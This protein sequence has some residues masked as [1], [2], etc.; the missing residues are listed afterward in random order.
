MTE[1]P[2]AVPLEP[3]ATLGILGGG[4]LGRLLVMAAAKL[5]LRC[6]VFCP[7][8]DSPAFEV[9]A[10]VTSAAYDDEGALQLFAHRVDVVT[11]EFENVPAHVAGLLAAQRPVYPPVAALD[12]TQDRL[13]EKRLA[14]SLGLATAPFAAVDDA[15]GLARQLNEIG[16]PALLKTRRFGYDGKGQAHIGNL[17]E[18]PDAFGAIGWQPAILE[19]VVLFSK[20][21]SVVAARG[22]DGAFAAYDPIENEHEDGILRRSRVPAR[23]L[24]ATT[25]AAVETA[26]TIGEALGF[27]GVFCVEMFVVEDTGGERLL[28]NEIAPRVHNSGHW[29]LDGCACSQFEQHVRA[30]AGWPLGCPDRHSDAEMQNL[31]GSD[32]VRVPELAREP[33]ASLYV[34]GKREMRPGRKMGHVTR[35]GACRSGR[36]ASPWRVDKARSFW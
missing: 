27:V 3:G 28:V 15:E 33:T 12:V 14:R 23:L 19:G 34:Y 24:P 35:L 32:I 31:I 10:A 7:D 18:A 13:A 22:R 21:I 30:V 5:G 17:A 29:T 26:R 11:Y 4:Q 2:G 25:V 8:T 16:F 20:E 1:P 6:H 9:A 36:E